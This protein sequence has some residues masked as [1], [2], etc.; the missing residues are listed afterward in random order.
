MNH[1]E[2]RDCDWMLGSLP[3]RPR[4]RSMETEDGDFG[5]E[6][7]PAT[8][9]SVSTFFL[10]ISVLTGCARVAPVRR[11]DSLERGGSPSSPEHAEA[12]H[13]QLWTGK[14]KRAVEVV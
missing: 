13:S 2:M 7:L 14:A 4:R 1:V 12:A 9:L 3:L 6:G 11:T 8:E 5:C 10:P